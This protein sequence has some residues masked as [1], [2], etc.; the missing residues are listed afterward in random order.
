MRIINF[1]VEKKNALSLELFLWLQYVIRGKGATAPTVGN[2]KFSSLLGR[3][4]GGMILGR[5]F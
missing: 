5:H 2:L 4:E 3:L 1:F